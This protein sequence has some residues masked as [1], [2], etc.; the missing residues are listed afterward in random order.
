MAKTLSNILTNV[1]SFLD[2]EAAEPTGT[3]LV[4]R[5]N[6]ADQAVWDASAI[7]QFKEFSEPY[8][9]ATPSVL[10]SLFTVSLP[11]DFKEFEEIPYIS[12]SPDDKYEQIEI[13]DRGKKDAGDSYFYLLGNPAKGYFAIFKNLTISKTLTITYQRFPS[14]LLTLADKCELSD[15]QYVVA[16]VESYVLQSRGDERFPFVNATAESK[17]LNMTGRNMKTPGGGVNRTKRVYK[18]PLS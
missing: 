6:L 18:N 7:S 3:E 16:K 2:L 13:R 12:G 11:A 14:G 8:D 5:S 9:V 15:P 4:T 1:N 17:L 10:T